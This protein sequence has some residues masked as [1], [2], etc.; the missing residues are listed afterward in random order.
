MIRQGY[1]DV[2]GVIVGGDFICGQLFYDGRPQTQK[3]YADSEDELIEMARAKKREFI[4][5]VEG[6]LGVY[7]DDSLW[8]LR[9]YE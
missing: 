3:F 9:I 8:Q 7:E 2:N 4:E 1:D 5:S 6:V